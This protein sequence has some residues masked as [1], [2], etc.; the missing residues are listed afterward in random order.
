[1]PLLLSTWPFGVPANEA[2]IPILER[3]DS[4]LDAVVEAATQAEG[5]LETDTVGRYSKPNRLGALQLDAAV[6]DGATGGCGA[7]GALEGVFT[8]TRVAREVMNDGR[9]VFLVGEGAIRFAL[10][11]GF[12]TE[13]LVD[14]RGLEWLEKDEAEASKPKRDT[15]HDTIGII[16]VDNAGDLAVACTTSGLGGKLPGRVGDSPIVGSGLYCDR[17]VGACV[18]TGVGEDIMKVCASFLVVERMRSGDSPQQ[19]CQEAIRRIA[20]YPSADPEDSARARTSA[21]L[22]CNLKGE[23]GAAVTQPKFK[24]AY[25]DGSENKLIEAA[26]LGHEF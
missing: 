10:K 14:T 2:A 15:G 22:A 26:V 13:R 8:A 18:A 17:T 16:A 19:A 3:G 21:V 12:K 24:Y 4:A 25:W 20:Q 7:V 9:H 11:R 6:M 23:V 5:S 1:M